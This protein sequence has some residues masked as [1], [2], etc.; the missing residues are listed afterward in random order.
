MNSPDDRILISEGEESLRVNTL[1]FALR[2]VFDCSNVRIDPALLQS[3]EPW[4][5]QGKRKGSK[6][7]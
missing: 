6:R 4:Q 7:K 5:R 2:R 1:V 3:K